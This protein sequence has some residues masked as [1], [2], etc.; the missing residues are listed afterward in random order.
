MDSNPWQVNGIEEHSKFQ[1]TFTLINS[2]KF[3]EKIDIDDL[4]LLPKQTGTPNMDTSNIK[5]EPV[6]NFRSEMEKEITLLFE[7]LDMMSLHDYD[8]MRVKKVKELFEKYYQALS[9]REQGKS[10]V[11]T[12]EKN[13]EAKI[14]NELDKKMK[15]ISIENSSLQKKIVEI[16]EEHKAA[17]AL[18]S[19]TMNSIVTMHEKA[20]EDK[21]KELEVAKSTNLS[22]SKKIQELESIQTLHNKNDRNT[23]ETVSESQIY[24]MKTDF[25][26]KPFKCESCDT[27]TIVHERKKTRE[28]IICDL[29]FLLPE[30]FLD[31]VTN[32]HEGKKPQECDKAYQE[33]LRCKICAKKLPNK[34]SLNSHIK[35]VHG[36][37]KFECGICHKKFSV[38]D[39]LKSHSITHTERKLFSCK[40]C[41]KEFKHKTSLNVHVKGRCKA[42]VLLQEEL[43]K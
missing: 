26:Q 9:S 35:G 19:K 33:S 21:T 17:M 37:K 42:K 25:K 7:E 39:H 4:V 13:L 1:S 6:E 16:T 22:L 27:S 14:E 20:L 30:D 10:A 40:S 18:N 12:I 23:S 43:T 38:N 11:E 34:V 8:Q 28:C 31:H 2:I 24:T 15:Q 3:E 32:F 5:Q 41:P 29:S 36:T